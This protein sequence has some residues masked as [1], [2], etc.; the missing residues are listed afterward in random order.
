MLAVYVRERSRPRWTLYGARDVG[1][2]VEVHEGMDDSLELR[3]ARRRAAVG[4]ANN[5]IANL[6]FEPKSSSFWRT[7][8]SRHR[9]ARSKQSP[10]RN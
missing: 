8:P 6:K 1:R 10:Q 4:E 3:W 5:V 7:S 2:S 9:L